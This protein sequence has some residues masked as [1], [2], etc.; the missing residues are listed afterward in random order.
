MGICREPAH[1]TRWVG[2]LFLFCTLPRGLCTPKQADTALIL[3]LYCDS[4]Q[5]EFLLEGEKKKPEITS[6]SDCLLHNIQ[7]SCRAQTRQECMLGICLVT[8]LGWF[9][10]ISLGPEPCAW[11]LSLSSLPALLVIEST[12]EWPWRLSPSQ[13]CPTRSLC[14]HTSKTRWLGWRRPELRSLTLQRV[15]GGKAEQ[16]QTFLPGHETETPGGSSHNICIWFVF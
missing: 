3:V 1:K 6:R 12:E 7:A 5:E 10:V 2:S 16:S 8:G 9:A 15:W 13:F 4:V 14:G 11:H